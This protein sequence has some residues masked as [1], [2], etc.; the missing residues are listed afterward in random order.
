MLPKINWLTK[1]KDFELVFKKGES[2]KNDFLIFKI[3]KNHLK[4]NRF[5]FVVSKKVSNKAS[6][7]NRIKRRLRGA[8]LNRLKEVNPPQPFSNGVGGGTRELSFKQKFPSSKKSMDVIIIALSRIN[9]KE[10]SEIQEVVTKF[11]KKI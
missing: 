11:L 1:K 3:L 6:K 9:G 4:E 10:F 2:I 5:G 8:V 7:R